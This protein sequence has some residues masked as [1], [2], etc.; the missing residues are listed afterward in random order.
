MMFISSLVIWVS[1]CYLFCLCFF[2]CCWFGE[3]SFFLVSGDFTLMFFSSYIILEVFCYNSFN[4]SR[5]LDCKEPAFSVGSI[6]VSHWVVLVEWTAVGFCKMVFSLD[7]FI[8]ENSFWEKTI[9]FLFLF[10]S[11]FIFFRYS[12]AIFTGHA[13]MDNFSFSWSVGCWSAIIFCMMVRKKA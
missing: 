4:N 11:S 10:T 7:S 3:S 12:S 9:F 2:C 8:G 6:L 5:Y 1:S 13:L